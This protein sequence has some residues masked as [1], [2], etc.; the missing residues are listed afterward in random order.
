MGRTGKGLFAAAVV[1]ALAA[2]GAVWA[3]WYHP[4]DSAAQHVDFNRDIRPIFNAHCITCHGG[5][6][7]A[8]GVSFSYREQALGKGKSGRPTIVPGSPRA[9]ELIARVTSKD[10]EFRMPLHQQPLSG[11]EIALLRRWID[12]GAPWENYWAFVPPKPQKLPEVRQKNWVRQP[13]DRFVL[14]RLEKE[15]LAPAGEA[16]KAALLR[17]VSLDLTGLPPTPKELEAFL[18]DPSRDAYERQVDRLLA[19]PA[20]GERWAALWLDLARYGDTKGFEKDRNRPGTW[21]YRDWV[22]GAFNRNMPYDKF[23]ITQLAGDLFAKPSMDDL[24][25]T[26]FHRQTQANDEGGTDDEEF[27]LAA[28]MDR[29]STTW[30]VLN[31]VSFNCVQC[32]SHPYDP[33]RHVEF[34]KFMAFFN[35]TRDADMAFGATL[36]DDWPVM[37]VPTD[38]NRYDEALQIQNQLASLRQ[39]VVKASRAQAEHTSWA[40][41]SILSGRVSEIEAIKRV[42]SQLQARGEPPQRG[43]ELRQRLT[44]AE[45][46]KAPRAGFRLRDGLAEKTGTVPITSVFSFTLSVALPEVTALRIE[47]P[48]AD[49]AKARHSPEKGFVVNRIDLSVVAPDGKE[50]PIPI[51]VLAPDS[52]EDLEANYVRLLRNAKASGTPSEVMQQLSANSG[53]MADPKLFR[54]NWVVAVPVTPVTLA[55]GSRIK[56]EL[57]QTEGINAESSPV[58]RVRFLSSSD[59]GWARFAND[60]AIQDKLVALDTLERKLKAVPGVPLPVQVEQANYE[61]RPTL[62]F[63][64]GSFL[65]PIGP[66]LPADTPALF[67]KFPAN[68]PRNRLA[69]AKWFFAPDQPLTARVAVNRTWEQLFGTGLVESLEDF[70]SAGEHPS[71]PELLD[72]LALHFQ[73]D[74]HWNMKALLRE[75]VSSATYRQSAA[76]TAA[77]KARDPR[78]RLLAHGPALRLTAEMVRD[79]A[80]LASGLLNPVMGGPPVMP[81]QPEGVWNVIANNPERWK[82]ATGPDRY[83]RAIYTYIKRTATYPSFVTFDI[84][85]RQVSQPRRIATNT[86]LQAL[87]TLNDPVF[88]QAALAL[89]ARM[90]KEGAKT[91]RDR[92][93]NA[94]NIGARSVLTRDLTTDERA[95]LHKLESRS[96]MAAAA[97]ALLNIDAALTR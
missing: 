48:P 33:I 68:A 37:H 17:R 11:N 91:P 15:Q 13:F 62:E 72:W 9:S 94:L 36:A 28:V 56:V 21:T 6:K 3:S 92:V 43:E 78:N 25:A 47:V 30:S 34:Y 90:A 60:P 22:I 26:S 57:T 7:Q 45:K 71:H 5:V 88:R 65:T 44:V 20:Y 19:S 93:D 95:I 58:P 80:L 32:H 10:S 69:L 51:R 89:A 87:V 24:I 38:R 59:P 35:T 74:L 84:P 79:Q 40:K 55:S 14:A 1:G 4:H 77:L 73:N 64:R 86:P 66:D 83:R 31:G 70:G 41:A 29:A 85:D 46:E 23:V 52:S 16:D 76:T 39:D 53:F 27:R 54:T 63:E 18:A 97:T 42:L 96:G 67:P 8:S 49:P 61:R 50:Q 2:G 12:Q 82:N 81:E 75:V